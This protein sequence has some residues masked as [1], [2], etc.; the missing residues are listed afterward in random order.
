MRRRIEPHTG[1]VVADF[2]K[3]S[4]WWPYRHEPLTPQRNQHRGILERV[5]V[6]KVHEVRCAQGDDSPVRNAS[7]EEIRPQLGPSGVTIHEKHHLG[8][9]KILLW[10]QRRR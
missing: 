1:S 5:T 7:V 10:V 6:E 2:L 9:L 8:T 3:P 4:H